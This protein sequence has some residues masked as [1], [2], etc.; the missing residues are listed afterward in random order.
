MAVSSDAKAEDIAIRRRRVRYRAWHRGTQEMDMILGHFVDAHIEAYD[1]PALDRLER[2]MEEA[3]TDLLMWVMGQE[4]PRED[5]DA[6]LLQ[7]L[8]NFQISRTKNS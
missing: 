1:H 7:E 5:V 2:L 3:D 8:T 4:P 6:I